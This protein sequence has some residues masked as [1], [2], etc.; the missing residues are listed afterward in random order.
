MPSHTHFFFTTA[1][2]GKHLWEQTAG[3]AEY[4][5]MKYEDVSETGP[6]EMD[7]RYYYNT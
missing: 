3:C 5:S 4:L 6:I 7:N 1:A 2:A